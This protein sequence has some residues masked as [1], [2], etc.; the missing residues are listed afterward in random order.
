MTGRRPVR[1]LAVTG[2]TG[3]GGAEIILGHL[4]AS[5]GPHVE[6]VLLGVDPDVTRRVAASRPG[7]EVRFMPP[8]RTK[9]DLAALRAQRRA[10]A[11]VGADVVQ[12]NLP[13]PAAEQYTVLAAVTVPRSRVVV[14]EHLP[15][16]IGSPSGRALKRATSRRLAAHL[17]VGSGA[18]R[19]VERLCGLPRGSVRGVPNGVPEAPSTPA[20]R[21]AAPGPVVGAIGRLH[22]QKGLDVLVRAVAGLAGVRLV[23]VGDGPERGALERLGQQLGLG[24]RLTITGWTDNP[25]SWLPALD[26]MALPSRFEGLPLVLLEAMH[27]G[28]PVVSTPVGSVA[29]ALVDGETGLLVPTDDVAALQ[30]ALGTLLGDP[31][32]RSAMGAAARERARRRFS[33]DVMAA[34]YEDVYDEIL[35]SSGSLSLS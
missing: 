22:H 15:M 20:V 8:A 16:P 26:V 34:A 18:A 21:R 19:E 4:L 28:L 10:I 24:D 14:V 12:V 11:A 35:A 3:W 25:R 23:L 31:T 33:A 1:L 6:P 17:A 7:M 9:R 5:L 29:D 13:V 27:A 30:A 32:R 2:A